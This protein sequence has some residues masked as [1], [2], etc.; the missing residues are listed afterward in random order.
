M[1]VIELAAAAKT[2]TAPAHV[3]ERTLN[4]ATL[5]SPWP[6]SPTSGPPADATRAPTSTSLSDSGTKSDNTLSD[7]TGTRLFVV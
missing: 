4:T 1:S 2:N 5:E 6:P 7:A 3:R